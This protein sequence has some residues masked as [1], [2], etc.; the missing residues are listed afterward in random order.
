MCN[1]TVA[2]N[3]RRTQNNQN[4]EADF[5]R[6]AAWRELGEICKKYLTKGRKVCVIGPVSVKTYTA[7]DGTTRAS[8]NVDAREIEFL[9][10][11]DD[12][13]T[14]SAPTQAA[15]APAADVQPNMT[16]VDAGDELP[17]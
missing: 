2:V 16:P 14:T 7:Q 8:M 12:G 1:F 10:A 17:F 5:F 3:R 11:K 15:P 9:S 4:P 13:Q 6:V